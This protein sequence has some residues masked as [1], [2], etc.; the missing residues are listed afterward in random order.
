[1]T[2][3]FLLMPLPQLTIFTLFSLTQLD[4]LFAYKIHHTSHL[5]AYSICIL[6]IQTKRE[7]ITPKENH[8]I[9]INY[10]LTVVPTVYGH[11]GNPSKNSQE[12]PLQHRH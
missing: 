10:F 3:V 5:F 4:I 7:R 11:S 9:V 8:F 1:M 2:S 12:S 6:G